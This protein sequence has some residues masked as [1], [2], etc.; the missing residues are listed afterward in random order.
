MQGFLPPPT[1][2]EP[3]VS[4]EKKFPFPSVSQ[5]WG[6][7]LSLKGDGGPLH[8]LRDYNLETYVPAS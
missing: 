7:C 5:S 4:P 3:Q 8:K 6:L 2:A 1:L